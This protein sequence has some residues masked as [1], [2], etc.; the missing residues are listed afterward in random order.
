MHPSTHALLG[1]V[2][3]RRLAAAS[4]LTLALPLV[5]GAQQ[6][7]KTNAIPRV[8]AAAEATNALKG[9]ANP[10]VRPLTVGTRHSS[11]LDASDP[12]LDDG[13]HV[14]LWAL[15]LQAGQQATVTMRSRDFDT[16][17]LM[18]QVDNTSFTAEND[19]FE[20]GSTDSRISFRAPATGVYAFL[21]NSYEGGARGNYTIEATVGGGQAGGQGGAMDE[22]MG[23]GRSSNALSYGQTVNGELS[24]ADR[25]L[26]DGSKYDEYTF[27]GSTGDRV[28]ITMT[29]SAFDTYL[30]LLG[31]GGD[32]VAN[33]DD[34]SDSDTNSQ[35]VFTLS[36]SGR[37]T[38]IANAYEAGSFGPYSLR[39]E[40]R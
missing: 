2:T 7:S 8:L 36:A 29:S 33:N 13:S 32:R 34:V 10:N 24:D 1:K 18:M 39:L 37:Y 19:D 40:K 15:E 38:I 31:P 4:A 21:A 11:Q 3:L 9:G 12:T 35:I 6:D 16:M 20:E 28:V 14:E 30:A 5:A 22:L 23:G 17:L 27:Q 26:D 25:T